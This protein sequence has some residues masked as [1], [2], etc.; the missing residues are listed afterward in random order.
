MAGS[1]SSTARAIEKMISKPIP[2]LKIVCLPFGF[3]SPNSIK[4]F[5][6][7]ETGQERGAAEVDKAS[8][9]LVDHWDES[10]IITSGLFYQVLPIPIG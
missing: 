3:S 2:L 5:R 9:Q 10:M 4:V 8:S 6:R 7:Q 1:V